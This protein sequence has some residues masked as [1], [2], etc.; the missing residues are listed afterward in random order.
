LSALLLLDLPLDAEAPVPW[1]HW[2]NEHHKVIAEG[3]LAN[4][5]ELGTLAESCAAVPCYALLPGA[6]VSAHRVVLPKGG[7][8]GM[9]ALPYQLE[10]KLC[11]DLDT[12]HLAVGV[13]QAK[14]PTDVLV[15]DHGVVKASLDLLRQSGLRI[16]AL[17]PDYAVLP[18]NTVVIDNTQVAANIHAQPMG[19]SSENFA[20]WQQ[21]VGPEVS[22]TPVQVYCIGDC[23]E[24]RLGAGEHVIE[25]CENRLRAFAIGFQ[26]WPL[27][28]L[29]GPYLLK[30]ESGEA[31]ARL[32]W[33]LIL[34]AAL[35]GLHWMSLGVQ[36]Y[37]D[38]READALDEAMVAVYQQTFPGSRVVNARSQMRS[39][40]N[41]LEKTGGKDLMMPWLEKVAATTKTKPGITLAQLN[42]ENDPAVMKL[43]LNAASY[44]VIDQWL[45]TLKAQ[46][47]NVER[48]AFGQQDGGIAG[49]IS[50]RGDAQ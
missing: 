25:Q 28:L 44:E 42:Y 7:R 20:V 6:A 2:D 5:R 46:G 11:T 29:S 37:R 38:N 30:D 35:L 27:S 9:A 12:V 39:Q 33:P 15:A 22:A 16:K 18:P 23:E 36:T 19:M 47:V 40:L 43:I 45:A 26:A 31:V 14:Q 4:G 1:L 10:D 49:Q 17:L 13:L 24:S 41:A 34:L 21:I 50:I 32:R 3:V 48:G 8:V